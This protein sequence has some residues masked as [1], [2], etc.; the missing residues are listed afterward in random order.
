MTAANPPAA[1]GGADHPSPAGRLA[2]HVCHAL[3]LLRQGRREAAE[4]QAENT[5]LLIVLDDLGA[6]GSDLELVARD[7]EGLAR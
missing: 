2:H 5:S 6:I 1:A 3:Y 7:L 4:G